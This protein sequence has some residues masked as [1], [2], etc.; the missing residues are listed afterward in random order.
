MTDDSQNSI[1]IDLFINLQFFQN[2]F[3]W[4]YQSIDFINLTNI[5]I[6]HPIKS[7]TNLYP[8]HTDFSYFVNTRHVAK[9]GTF[10]T[11]LTQDICCKT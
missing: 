1:L 8:I 4:T 9:L 6:C 3:I 7:M 11:V 10:H 2:N 5:G